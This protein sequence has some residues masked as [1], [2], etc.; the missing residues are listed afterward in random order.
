MLS[1]CYSYGG[2]TFLIRCNIIYNPYNAIYLKF[3][4]D[5]TCFSCEALLKQEVITGQPSAVRQ[6]SSL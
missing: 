5:V 2:H 6:K 4:R 1:L 3:L